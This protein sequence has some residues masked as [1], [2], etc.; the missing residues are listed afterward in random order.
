MKGLTLEIQGNKRE[1][2]ENYKLALEADPS[3]ELAKNA[4]E[5]IKN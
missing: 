2:L 1:A 4:I 3:Y 5:T